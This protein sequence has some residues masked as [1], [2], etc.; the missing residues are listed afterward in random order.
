MY[1]THSFDLINS[2]NKLRILIESIK[3]VTTI[4]LHVTRYTRQRFFSNNIF[5]ID[6]SCH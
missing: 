6:H 4:R 2:T 5:T 3:I 1:G